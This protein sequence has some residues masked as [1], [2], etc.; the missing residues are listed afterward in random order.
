MNIRAKRAY[1]RQVHMEETSKILCSR[2]KVV[3]GWNQA[4]PG[5]RGG[6][7]VVGRESANCSHIA[8]HMI[9]VID[10]DRE[11]ADS[12]AYLLMYLDMY[13]DV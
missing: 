10:R 3:R 7:V 2:K 9:T 1:Q 8:P 4:R 12:Y 13:L 11:R 5:A 6:G